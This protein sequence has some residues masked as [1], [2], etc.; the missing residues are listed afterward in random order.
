MSQFHNVTVNGNFN[1]GYVA[2]DMVSQLAPTPRVARGSTNDPLLFIS[3]SHADA[4]LVA[5]IVELLGVAL[6]TLPKS[7]IRA[8]SDPSLSMP[9]GSELNQNLLREVES[10]QVVLGVLTP[11][12]LSSTYVMMELTAGFAAKKLLATY[13]GMT[14]ESSGPFSNIVQRPLADGEQVR[15]LLIDIG[16]R[17]QLTPMTQ[18]SWNPHVA[19]L[20]HIASQHNSA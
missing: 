14:A 19:R 10:A 20:T 17:L 8:S 2:G 1:A 3:H 9:T 11:K 7:R 18:H 13:A 4:T 15:K 5:A 12:A 6:P 16:E